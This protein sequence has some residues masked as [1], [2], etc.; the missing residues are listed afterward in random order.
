M[1]LSRI[2]PIRSKPR[3]GRLK[4]EAIAALREQVWNEQGGRCIQCRSWFSLTGDPFKRM[5]L[6]HI[7]NKRMWGDR[8]DNVCGKCFTCH[9]VKEHAY[10]PSGEKP[11]P[12]K[13]R[14]EDL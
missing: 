6:A 5:H 13:P 12:P 9:I 2:N 3:P 4:G 1:K 7:R 11:C 10:G 8:R 14:L